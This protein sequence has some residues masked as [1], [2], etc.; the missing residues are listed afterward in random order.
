M[1]KAST[2]SN[3][4]ENVPDNFRFTFKLSKAVTHAKGL[5]FNAEDV[6]LFIQTIAHTGN[7]RGCLLI[8]FPPSLEIDKIGQVENILMCIKTAD[9]DN[10]WKIA[11]VS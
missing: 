4:A 3:W 2:V 11:I 9:P 7:K 10:D 6:N 1:P 8:Q 5:D